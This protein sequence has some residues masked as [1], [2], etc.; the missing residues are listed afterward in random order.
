M[1]GRFSAVCL[2]SSR[3]KR[4]TATGS[5][6]RSTA[7][8][9]YRESSGSSSKQAAKFSRCGSRARS[10][11][12]CTCRSSRASRER[13]HFVPGRARDVEEP[14]ALG[15]ALDRGIGLRRRGGAALRTPVQRSG[16]LHGPLRHLVR[17]ADLHARDGHRL[18]GDRKRPCPARPLAAAHPCRLVRRPA[19]RRVRR[20]RPLLRARVAR[21]LHGSDGARVRI[22]A[23]KARRAPARDPLGLGLAIGPCLSRRFPA[24]LDERRRARARDPG[25]DVARGRRRRPPPA[26]GP[27]APG[28][29]E[30]A[31][32]AKSA[33]TPRSGAAAARF[34]SSALRRRLALRPLARRSGDLQPAR[35]GAE[36]RLTQRRIPP[37]LV[38]LAIASALVF[39]LYWSLA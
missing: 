23:E 39:L 11:K 27:D 26:V 8:P 4:P 1:P 5:G 17:G 19:R 37:L 12:T 29:D 14:L 2:R 10:W 32:P 21:V 34:R 28:G 35:A 33:G 25:V 16:E 15:G 24:G 18:R 31:R 13:D 38:A 7:R 3:A 20:S 9:P 22:R 36:A 30:A 6:S